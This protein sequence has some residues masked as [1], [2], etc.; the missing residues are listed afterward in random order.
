[1]D[2]APSPRDHFFRALLERP[3]AAG[4]LLREQLP[5]AIAEQRVGDLSRARSRTQSRG[6][7]RATASTA[8]P[9]LTD[10]ALSR[11]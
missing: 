9:L 10:M 11:T 4:A 2:H 7:R 1:M 3:K 6:A 8:F 5:P